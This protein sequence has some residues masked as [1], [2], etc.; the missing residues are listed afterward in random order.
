MNGSQVCQINWSR[1]EIEM[2]KYAVPEFACTNSSLERDGDGQMPYYALDPNH[3]EFHSSYPFGLGEDDELVW[4]VTKGDIHD[5]ANEYLV[6]DEES[7]KL[8]DEEFDKL[9]QRI[10]Y[11]DDGELPDWLNMV[12]TCCEDIV[13]QREE[14]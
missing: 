8:T 7:S 5:A 4:W 11:W 13:K 2:L 9:I 6:E 14:L 1:Q 10:R 3:P 12:Y